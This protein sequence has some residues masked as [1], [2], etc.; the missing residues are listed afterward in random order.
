MDIFRITD[1]IWADKLVAS[2]RPARWNSKDVE[3][4]YFAQSVSL[5]ILE[6]AVHR[7]YIELRDKTFR[8]VQVE[9]P[10]YFDEIKEGDLPIGWNDITMKATSIC[11]SF[12]DNWI[13]SNS[14]LLLRLP[15][16]I[17]PGEYNFLV[18]PKHSD[19]TKLKIIKISSFLFDGR[20]K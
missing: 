8:L 6:N 16:V 12:G 18:N 3:I 1:S 20:I 15:S 17:S 13:L 19:F 2:D 4:L 14:S 11:R 10:D 9:V 5:A 7:S